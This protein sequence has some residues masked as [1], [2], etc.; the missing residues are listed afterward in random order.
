VIAANAAENKTAKVNSLFSLIFF[1]FLFVIGYDANIGSGSEVFQKES[2]SF[3]S[4]FFSELS[5]PIHGAHQL[6]DLT[7]A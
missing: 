4:F 7:H 6:T 2:R 3:F 5:Y 1:I